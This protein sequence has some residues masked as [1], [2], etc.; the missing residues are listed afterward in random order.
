M[1]TQ[2]TLSPNINWDIQ[3][4]PLLLSGKIIGDKKA[5]LRNDNGSLLGIVGKDYFPVSNQSLLELSKLICK[6]GEFELKGFDEINNGRV[7]LAFLQNKNPNLKLNNC[8]MREFLII[9]NSHDGTRPF[10]IGTGSTLIRCENQFYST[11]KVFRKKHTSPLEYNEIL[12]SQIVRLYK[13]KKSQVY[14]VFDGMEQVPVRENQIRQMVKE[15]ERLLNRE[16]KDSKK[17]NSLSPS[18]QTLRACID[19]E[20]RELGNNAFGLFNGVTWYTSHEMRNCDSEL[21]RLNGTAGRINQKAFRFCNN[22]KQ[23]QIKETV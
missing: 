18:M 13:Q 7:I 20:M 12:A 21:S 2:T 1:K 11:L 14:G 23:L 5:I 10:Y 9:G 3:T 16:N 6:A 19:R 4:E 22:L 15:I 17:E 8:V